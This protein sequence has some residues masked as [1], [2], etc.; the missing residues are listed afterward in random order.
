MT[1]ESF[2]ILPLSMYRS[3]QNRLEHNSAEQKLDAQAESD[4]KPSET[5]VEKEELGK[6]M[7]L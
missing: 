1:V 4:E 6:Y 3:I 2:V 5:H 7:Q